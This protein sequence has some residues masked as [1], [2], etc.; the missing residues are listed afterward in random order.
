MYRTAATIGLSLIIAL[1]LC[2]SDGHAKRKKG[3]RPPQKPAQIRD[4]TLMI[5][6]RLTAG[7]VIGKAGDYSGD[8]LQDKIVYGAAISFE[9]HFSRAHAVGLNFDIVFKD[10]NNYNLNAIR[11]FSYSA[12]YLF[13]FSPGKRRSG[14]LRPEIGFIKGTLPDYFGRNLDLDTHPYLRLGLGIFD[15]TASRTNTRFEIFYKRVI[16]SGHELDVL[17]GGEINFNAQE[18]GIEFG[19]GIP[20]W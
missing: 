12:S 5:V 10:M 4:A 1:G 8:R 19:L 16:S 13:R 7:S 9:Y 11:M 2:V 20:L 15:Y 17:S 18:I 14:Y 6:P 3:E